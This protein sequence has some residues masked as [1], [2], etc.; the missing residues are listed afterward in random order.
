MDDDIDP[1]E[2]RLRA[3]FNTNEW[4]GVASLTVEE[5]RDGTHWCKV[6]RIDGVAPGGAYKIRDGRGRRFCLATDALGRPIDWLTIDSND[7][8]PDGDDRDAG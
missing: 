4:S 7:D 2:W 1:Q 5:S 6:P 3:W 8:D